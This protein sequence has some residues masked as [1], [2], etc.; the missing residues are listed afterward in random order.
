MVKEKI[1]PVSGTIAEFSEE[2]KKIEKALPNI[3]NVDPEKV[4][5]GLAK[6]LLTLI[7]MIRRLLENQAIRRIEGGNL[8]EAEIERM[9]QAFMK[10]NEKMKELKLIFG[11]EEEDLDLKL[12]PLGRLIK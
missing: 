7:E 8:S 6:L 12:G 11:L 2:L 5:H 10:M 9:G 1:K 4:E 3:I